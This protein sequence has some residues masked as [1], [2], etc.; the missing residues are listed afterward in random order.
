MEL[1]E[2]TLSSQVSL[3]KQ[4]APKFLKAMFIFLLLKKS[5]ILQTDPKVR[6]TIQTLFQGEY[7]YITKCVGLCAITF[8]IVNCRITVI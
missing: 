4:F 2:T 1:L 5:F 8:V 7:S 6:N 3:H